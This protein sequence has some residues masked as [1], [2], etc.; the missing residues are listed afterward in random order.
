MDISSSRHNSKCNGVLAHEE[1]SR[2]DKA[3]VHRQGM[4]A[5]TKVCESLGESIQIPVT[6]VEVGRSPSI[7]LTYRWGDASQITQTHRAGA[8]AG[9]PAGRRIKWAVH[10]LK[11]VYELKAVL[12]LRA[13]HELKDMHELK[14]VHELRAVHG[15]STIG[16]V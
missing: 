5:C 15:T 7:K 1:D 10:E 4:P 8:P 11:A 3:P 14:A 9:P 13:A 6:A 16:Y 12:E 2:L